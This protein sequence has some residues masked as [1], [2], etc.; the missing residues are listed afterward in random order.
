MLMKISRD[1]KT[2]SSEDNELKKLKQYVR[3]KN[4]CSFQK[5][6]NKKN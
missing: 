6:K 1:K 4:K 5:K 3:I 2:D